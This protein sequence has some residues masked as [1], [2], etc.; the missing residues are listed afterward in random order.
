MYESLLCAKSSEPGGGAL[1]QM[2]P[3]PGW[4]GPSALL[5]AAQ[6]GR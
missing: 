2:G 3:C 1:V 5:P 6:A 4:D